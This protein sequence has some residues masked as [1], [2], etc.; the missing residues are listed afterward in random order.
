MKDCAWQ[1]ASLWL[2]PPFSHSH[3]TLTSYGSFDAALLLHVVIE[4]R[5]LCSSASVHDGKAAGAVSCMEASL[6]TAADPL[7]DGSPYR[8]KLRFVPGD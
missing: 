4:L 2:K 1:V 3:V 6:Q 5:L 7:L 8:G